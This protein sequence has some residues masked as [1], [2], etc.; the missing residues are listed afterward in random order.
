MLWQSANTIE[1]YIALEN[2]VSPAKSAGGQERWASSGI[3]RHRADTQEQGQSMDRE[4]E[5]CEE[6]EVKRM[7]F[8]I[9]VYFK[10]TIAVKIIFS[11]Q[12]S[13]IFTRIENLCKRGLDLGA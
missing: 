10:Y 4:G 8:F 6:K 7:L 2:Y 13:I 12:K 11:I 9:F 5:Q 1:F 3:T